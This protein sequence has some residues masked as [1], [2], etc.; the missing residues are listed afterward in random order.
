MSI[1]LLELLSKELDREMDSTGVL[2]TLVPGGLCDW[3]DGGMH[4]TGVWLVGH[5]ASGVMRPEHGVSGVTRSRH[6]VI[7]VTRS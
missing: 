4:L 3:R 6:G 5:G 1:S 2:S 7:G